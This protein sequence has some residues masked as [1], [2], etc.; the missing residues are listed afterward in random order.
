MERKLNTLYTND[1]G[2]AIDV[3]VTVEGTT[4]TGSVILFEVDGKPISGRSLMIEFGTVSAYVPA[5]STYQAAT[6]AGQTTINTWYEGDIPIT[7]SNKWVDITS[8]FTLNQIYRNATG[9]PI[10]ISCFGLNGDT[11]VV[12]NLQLVIDGII[13]NQ[14]TFQLPVS[15]NPK[16]Y[17][18]VRGIIPTGSTYQI[19]T[20]AATAKQIYKINTLNCTKSFAVGK[21]WQDVTSQRTLLGSYTNDTGNCL[22]IS[23]WAQT[24]VTGGMYSF[25]VNMTS[26]NTTEVKYPGQIVNWEGTALP[27]KDYSVNGD[28]E[29]TPHYRWFEL[30]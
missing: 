5:G 14:V 13:I 22:A 24:H 7:D 15:A 18:W 2:H 17:G 3:Q 23:G 9:T 6:I 19:V 29:D 25:Y 30:R 11:T 1:T 4:S 8:T 27:S 12:P 10:A 21:K 16:A 20:N 28:P 26:V